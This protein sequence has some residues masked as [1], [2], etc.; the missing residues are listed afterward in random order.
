MMRAIIFDLDG[1]LV[2][3]APD[4]HAVLVAVLAEIDAPA[5]TLEEVR[6]MVGDGARA[7]VRRGLERAEVSFDERLL[8]R[9]F[10]RFLEIYT[11]A[12]CQSSH[13]YPDVHETLGRL[14]ARDLRLAICTNKPQLPAE[15]LAR[16]LGLVP[17]IEAI[18]GG[19]ALAVRKPDPRHLE[20]ALGRLGA[21]AAEAVMVGDSRTDLL[22]ARA[23]G[24]P[25][26]LVSFGY[27]AVPARE[28]GADRV[29]DRFGDLDAALA[30]L[31]PAA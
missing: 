14:A 12:P 20:A 16:T 21:T 1:T 25:C 18:L 29:I 7:L 8:D 9:L 11:A 22:T 28:L 24:V 13:V 2:E 31:P 30:A 23:A 6:R 3:T 26:V 15:A 4:L 17:P 10:N 27:T 19:D 5:P